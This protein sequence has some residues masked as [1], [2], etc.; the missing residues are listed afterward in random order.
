MGY[1]WEAV[2]CSPKATKEFTMQKN[3]HIGWPTAL[4]GLVL[5]PLLLGADHGDGLRVADAPEYDITDF[6]VFPRMDG[7]NKRLSFILS[8]HPNSTQET[9]FAP[10]IAYRVKT[11]PISGFQDEPFTAIV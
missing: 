6:F 3:K 11:R 2:M 7:T 5:T 10:D 8:V 4:L 1:S 9:R